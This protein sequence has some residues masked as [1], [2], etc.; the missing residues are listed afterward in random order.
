M[1]LSVCPSIRPYER[2]DLRIYKSQRLGMTCL[3]CI[4]NAGRVYYM[5]S[6][7]HSISFLSRIIVKLICFFFSL[8]LIL[9]DLEISY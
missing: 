4:P 6:I 3:S 9:L 8:I 7:T 2:L 1:V 5:L